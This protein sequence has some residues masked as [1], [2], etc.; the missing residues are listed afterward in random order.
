MYDKLAGFISSMEKVGNHI[1]QA[2]DSY[3]KAFK[4]L[5]DG[6]GS[7]ISRATQLK[8]L[9]ATTTKSISVEDDATESD[10]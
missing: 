1:K 6:R 4:Q 8:R 10:A 5:K 9:G 7:L 2:D 3:E